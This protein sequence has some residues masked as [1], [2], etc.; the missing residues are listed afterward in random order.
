VTVRGEGLARWRAEKA[1]A[2]WPAVRSTVQT[3]IV[4]T[5][6]AP[7]G[8]PLSEIS[9]RCEVDARAVGSALRS[10]AAAGWMREMDARLVKDGRYMVLR[11]GADVTPADLPA[12]AP[13]PDDAGAGSW[14]PSLI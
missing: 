14:L 12:P 9:R 13:A 5:H 10:E 4:E 6:G 7:N 1:A 3:M 2:L 11:V 8:L